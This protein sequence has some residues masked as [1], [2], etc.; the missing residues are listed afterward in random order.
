[1]QYPLENVTLVHEKVSDLGGSV[2]WLRGY[3]ETS[4][5][6][7]SFVYA[8]S[9]GDL[10]DFYM[11]CLG[12]WLR[13]K[14]YRASNILGWDVYAEGNINGTY[15][16]YTSLMDYA[17]KR[18]TVWIPWFMEISM[19]MLMFSDEAVA[20]AVIDKLRTS[21][22]IY[23]ESVRSAITGV[24]E[25]TLMVNGLNR[26]AYIIMAENINSA[27]V[28]ASRAEI[29]IV[30]IEPR[31]YLINRIT[32]WDV[33][34]LTIKGVLHEGIYKHV[35]NKLIYN[36]RK[37]IIGGES[38]PLP[39][40]RILEEYYDDKGNLCRRPVYN[41]TITISSRISEGIKK[42]VYTTKRNGFID[43]EVPWYNATEGKFI[44]GTY[45]IRVSKHQE[46][47]YDPGTLSSIGDLERL[48]PFYL[49]YG[50][51]EVFPINQFS[52]KIDQSGNIEVDN[53]TSMTFSIADT[54]ILG[55]DIVLVLRRVDTWD[56]FVRNNIREFLKEAGIPSNSI[57]KIMGISTYY[58]TGY[59]EYKVGFR[60][61]TW[62]LTYGRISYM[63]NAINQFRGV[64]GEIDLQTIY[65]EWGHGVKQVLLTDTGVDLG[66]SHRSPGAPASSMELAYDEG[67]AEFFSYLLIT[68]TGIGSNP[69]DD[70]QAG[71]TGATPGG[72]DGRFI[73]GRVAGYWI[74]LY[75]IPKHSMNKTLIT[76]SYEDFI[77]TSMAYK[78]LIGYP[79]RTI[80]QWINAYILRKT[81]A[82][83]DDAKALA[84]ERGFNLPALIIDVEPSDLFFF[85]ALHNRDPAIMGRPL[86]LI[87][88]MEAIGKNN[89][90]IH[91]CRGTGCSPLGVIVPAIGDRV[92]SLASYSK[93]VL[94]NKSSGDVLVEIDMDKD[95][96]LELLTPDRL[97]LVSGKIH[98]RASKNNMIPVELSIVDFTLYIHSDIVVEKQPDNTTKL[99]VL[100]GSVDVENTDTGASATVEA[101]HYI[102]LNNS[103]EISAPEIFNNVS[104]WWLE[105]RKMHPSVRRHFIG[106]G[107]SSDGE[108]LGQ[109]TSFT[110]GV[111]ETIASLVE[112]DNPMENHTITWYFV[113]ENGFDYMI[114]KEINNSIDKIWA[115]VNLSS[116]DPL[117]TG[118]GNWSIMIYIND[119]LEAV[120]NIS[121]TGNIP[122][123]VKRTITYPQPINGSGYEFDPEAVKIIEGSWRENNT[124]TTT[125]R[126]TTT[127]TG[128]NTATRFTST[129]THKLISSP[130]N[131]TNIGGSIADLLKD[132]VNKVRELNPLIILIS[133]VILAIIIIVIKKH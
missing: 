47:L 2:S 80:D 58:R 117:F 14:Y 77:K 75:N 4:S 15:F 65:H 34:I 94:I 39:T 22:S 5:G 23:A 53:S 12:W 21:N 89:T 107:I 109:K 86:A 100:E 49:K 56:M 121:V 101:N 90:H 106:T 79:P 95:T 67:H 30:E 70:Y 111:D 25:T 129:T 52:F 99:Y 76:Y 27:M 114:S 125:A 72:V 57:D 113:C 84:L 122:I 42:T 73:E 78:N 132:L 8:V 28:N 6:N 60:L 54:M 102:I 33:D 115:T 20:T 1:M 45:Y 118:Y 104:T 37:Y 81:I 71:Y 87:G 92:K 108:I 133:L 38:A 126:I 116:I 61:F 91:V 31:T 124:E 13:T 29:M 98:V 68:Y 51:W 44:A 83:I 96:E 36:N 9:K 93:I 62:W 48:D 17:E 19:L 103:G 18:G 3:T 35:L 131:L 105:P 130:E 63:L 74:K 123:P 128:G 46:P 55:P 40:L 59:D 16:K 11:E 127:T 66:G 97:C 7:W 50:G 120:E 110:I 10:G 26:R 69:Y 119:V 43:G 32:F 64:Y 112:I 88:N 24:N 41:A 85:K 82:D